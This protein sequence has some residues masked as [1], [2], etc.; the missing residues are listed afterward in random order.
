LLRER[1]R[2][3]AGQT[4]TLVVLRRQKSSRRHAEN[5][6]VVAARTPGVSD[7][8]HGVRLGS[9]KTTTASSATKMVILL[10]IPRND[11]PIWMSASGVVMVDLRLCK[12]DR[13]EQAGRFIRAI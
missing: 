9:E 7:A 10:G 8:E 11:R 2:G 3:A 4:W 1:E 13:L 6:G 12:I 5:D